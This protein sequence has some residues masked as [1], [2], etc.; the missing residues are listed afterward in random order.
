MKILIVASKFI[1]PNLI[2]F[3][4]SLSKLGVE[5]KLIKDTD[6]YDGFSIKKF[7]KEKEKRENYRKIIQDFNPNVVLVDR[8]NSFGITVLKMKIPL[9]ILLRGNY[10]E[11][12]D[13]AYET[14]YKNVSLRSR[15]VLWKTKQIAKKCFKDSKLILPVCK[16]LE[17]VVKQHYS[18]KPTHVMHLGIDPSKWYS[19]SGMNLKHPCVG[20]VQSAN[21]WGKT[22]EMLIL[23]KVIE[24]M[25][26]VTFYWAGDGPYQDKI[27]PILK[28]F[29]N[30]EWIGSLKHPEKVRQFLTEIDIYALISGL[31]MTPV[32]LLE[33][34][35]MKKPVIATNVGGISETMIDRK[36]GLLIEK[37]SSEDCIEKISILLN[38]EKSVKLGVGGDEFVKK[39]FNWDLSAKVFLK[40]CEEIL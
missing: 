1:Y 4:Q 24:A 33:A 10:W 38:K 26:E 27:L 36:T 39:N 5:C 34:Q 29:K 20:L 21:I 19:E 37:G 2:E 30:F 28:K 11:E 35:I 31:D 17:N 25:P 40:K 23:S 6:N 14:I 22:K 16:Y 7:R 13:L 9:M 32:S 8:R 15:L 18:D 12:I 3:E